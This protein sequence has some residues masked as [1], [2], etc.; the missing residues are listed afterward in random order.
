MDNR[1]LVA[2]Y[3]V[4]IITHDTDLGEV[5][6][7]NVLLQLR[8]P[9]QLHLHPPHKGPVPLSATTNQYYDNLLTDNLFFSLKYLSTGSYKHRNHLR[10]PI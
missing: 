10:G 6:R 5:V 2:T 3:K 1:D 7:V 4:V 8:V 9:G